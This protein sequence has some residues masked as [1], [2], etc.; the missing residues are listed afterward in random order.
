MN[1]LNTHYRLL[2]GL[3]EA[4][5]VQNVDLDLETLSRLRELLGLDSESQLSCQCQALVSTP[6]PCGTLADCGV[7]ALLVRKTWKLACK[8]GPVFNLNDLE[9]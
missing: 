2:L 4:W 3:D 7:C 6:M 8:D 5:E 1:D 9:W